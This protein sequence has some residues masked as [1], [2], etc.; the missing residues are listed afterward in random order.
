MWLM[1]KI[2]NKYKLCLLTEAIS[3]FSEDCIKKF[4]A[5]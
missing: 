4:V 1:S 3:L 2:S 5:K